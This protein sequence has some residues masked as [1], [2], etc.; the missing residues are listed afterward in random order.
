MRQKTTAQQCP[1]NES[2][3]RALAI[4][5]AGI[6][7]DLH[8]VTEAAQRP[9]RDSIL[10]RFIEPL[11]AFKS[12]A[13]AKLL[14]PIHERIRQLAADLQLP[15]H[16][17]SITRSLTAV[18]VLDEIAV[19]EVEPARLRGYGAVD[20]A[21]ADYHDRELPQLRALLAALTKTLATNH[22]I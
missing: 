8:R 22:R 11:P 5:L 3:R 13:L 1:L 4:V 6:E 14:R 15:P 12:D 17:E 9:S 21:T 20:A 19:I 10:T 7:Q 18:L 2:Q 16:E